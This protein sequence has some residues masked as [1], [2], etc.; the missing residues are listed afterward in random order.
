MVL[1]A[2][3]LP[4]TTLGLR[5]VCIDGGDNFLSTEKVVRVANITS[6][7]QVLGLDPC[8]HELV[9]YGTIYKCIFWSFNS[10]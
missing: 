1:R 9:I 4:D 8:L 2:Q 7:A 3:R 6:G 10:I 5:V